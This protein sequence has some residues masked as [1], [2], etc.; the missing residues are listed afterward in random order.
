VSRSSRRVGR[1]RLDLPDGVDEAYGSAPGTRGLRDRAD[2]E[3]TLCDGVVELVRDA[4]PFA[5]SRK[6]EF[7]LARTDLLEPH[8]C[9]RAQL[10]K[11]CDR[12]VAE[13]G[14]VF[15]R[16]PRLRLIIGHMGELLPS[17][18][19]RA[20]RMLNGLSGLDRQLREY[21]LEN[22]YITTSG[23]FDHAPFAAAIQALGTD[24]ILFSVDYPYSSNDDARAF[25]DGLPISSPDREK[26]S[27]VNAEQLLKLSERRQ[28]R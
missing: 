11:N 18:P 24:R 25:L 12:S 6:L 2:R 3:R 14:G 21:F 13:L 4:L 19:S 1:G 26:I 27:H 20:S 7:E 8:R 5:R 23:I 15:D 22:I 10:I 28:A 16:F 9:V 17:M